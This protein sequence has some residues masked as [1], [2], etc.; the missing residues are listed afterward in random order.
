MV[1]STQMKFH[2]LGYFWVA[3]EIQETET[4]S[5]DSYHAGLPEKISYFVIWV[6]WH[7]K[8]Q[9]KQLINPY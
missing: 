2:S 4:I 6:K 1:W 9:S 5:M 7:I 3:A 8:G